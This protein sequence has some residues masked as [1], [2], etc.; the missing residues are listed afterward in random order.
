MTQQLRVDFDQ[1]AWEPGPPGCRF[2]VAL[3]GTRQLRLLEFT[4]AFVEPDW[5]TRAHAGIVLEGEL[6]V[7]FRGRIERY[8]RGDGL[9]IP[10]G[11]EFGH[12]ASAISESVL[13]FIVED[14][15]NES[16]P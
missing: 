10:A 6:E 5:C 2:K 14:A 7:D 16:L 12:K 3:H 1:I 4:R 8:R 15:A 11:M 13:L 9:L